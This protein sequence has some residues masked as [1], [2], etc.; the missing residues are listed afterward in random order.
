MSHPAKAGARRSAFLLLLPAVVLALAPAACQ[1]RHEPVMAGGADLPAEVVAAPFRVRE[2][3]AFAAANPDLMR[4][5]PCYCGCSAIGHASNYE[6]YVA[7]VGEDGRITYDLHA[8]GCSVC[9]EITQDARRLSEQGSPVSEIR[10][11][12]DGR[13]GRY[14]PSNMP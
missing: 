2:A 14:G 8:L 6:C 10:A 1:P 9:V 13:Y 3:Y 11:F 5:I 4:H 7:S 12:I